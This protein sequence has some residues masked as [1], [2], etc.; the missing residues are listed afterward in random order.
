MCLAE[1][2]KHVVLAH[3][4]DLD[5]PYHDHVAVRFLEDAVAHYLLDTARVALG[6]PRQRCRDSGGSSQQSVAERIL[7]NELELPA[8]QLLQ[9][10]GLVGFHR[11]ARKGFRK[12]QLRSHLRAGWRS[13]D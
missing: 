9:L 6:Q 11:R 7:A 4:V 3:R 2:W 8:H 1:E 13:S 12:C 5:I 10:D